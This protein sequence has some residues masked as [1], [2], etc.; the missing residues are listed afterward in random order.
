MQLVAELAKQIDDECEED[1]R[2]AAQIRP[3]VADSE[4]VGFNDWLRAMVVLRSFQ[5]PARPAPAEWT[6]VDRSLLWGCIDVW[7]VP[8]VAT[9]AQPAA[10]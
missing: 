10:R 3:R 4:G 7:G 5:E 9:A 6:I 1:E 2:R 8:E